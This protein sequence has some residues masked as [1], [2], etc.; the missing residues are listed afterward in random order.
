[1]QL[2]LDNLDYEP[3]PATGQMTPQTEA[4]LR[5][6]QNDVGLPPTGRP[7]ATTIAKLNETYD[8]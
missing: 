7:D 3:G 4:A 5:D 2:R 6:F 1:M 8:G